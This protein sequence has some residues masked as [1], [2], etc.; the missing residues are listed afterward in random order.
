MRK[1]KAIDTMD[2]TVK[3]CAV[4]AANIKLAKIKIHDLLTRHLGKDIM[5]CNYLVTRE[6]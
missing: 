5:Y 2:S 3:F 4:Y 1:Y 6:A